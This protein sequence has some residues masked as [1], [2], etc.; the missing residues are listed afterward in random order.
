MRSLKLG[1]VGCLM[2]LGLWAAGPVNVAV[3]ADGDQYLGAWKGTW[4]GGG[5]G[6]FDLTFARGADG[7]ITGSVAV[8]TDMGNYNATLSALSFKDG[9]FSGAYDY[10]PDVQGE[11]TMAGNFDAKT[12]T[13]TWSLGPKGKPAESMAAG[14]WKVAK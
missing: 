8:T 2:L 3:A 9:K 5:S 14:T 12:G 4:E 7:K 6:G 10:P 11:I 13:G 1:V